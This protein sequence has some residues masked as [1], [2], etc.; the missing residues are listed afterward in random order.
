MKQTRNKIQK[1]ENLSVHNSSPPQSQYIV[2]TPFAA[3]IA[4]SLLGY[5]SISLAH[6]ATGISAHS[7]VQQSSSHT[8]DTQFD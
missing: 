6:L 2:K 4:A 3:I 5:V 7:G 8:A 1:T